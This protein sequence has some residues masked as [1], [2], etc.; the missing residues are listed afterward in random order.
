M[1]ADRRDYLN[2]A[3]LASTRAA[4]L[5]PMQGQAYLHLAEL[6]FLQQPNQRIE[7]V[8]LDQAV[9]VRPYDGTVLFCRG[10]EAV[11]DGDWEAGLTD[12]RCAFR[13]GPEVRQTIIEAVAPQVTPDVFLTIFEP[14]RNGFDKLFRYYREADQKPQA[15][16]VGRRYVEVLEQHAQTLR[17]T[18]A[19]R[20]W[21]A[22]QEIYGYLEMFPEAAVAAR[23]AVRTQPGDYR[24]HYLLGVRLWQSQQW[25]EALQEFGWC[26]N[27]R[28]GDPLVQRKVAETKRDMRTRQTARDET[29]TSLNR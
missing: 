28:P 2:E 20:H 12:W 27:R 26:L 18:A 5:S 14:D 19:T 7:Q 1:L 13:H 3:Q 21:E 23:R 9:R 11:F 15:Q 6:A 8:L 25:N 10:R 16:A 4:R 22:I 17:G 24:L 29:D